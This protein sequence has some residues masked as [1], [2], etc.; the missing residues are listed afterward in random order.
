MNIN[1]AHILELSNIKMDNT[2]E[3][4]LLENQLSNTIKWLDSIAKVDT[5]NIEPMYNRLQDLNIIHVQDQNL[6]ETI[7]V[8]DILCNAPETFETFF[9]V[10]RVV[11]A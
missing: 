10:P 6:T 1:I 9:T 5:T 8:E 4:I 2:E 11:D 3:V 7:P